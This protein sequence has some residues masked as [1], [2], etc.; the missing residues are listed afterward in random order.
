MPELVALA[1]RRAGIGGGGSSDSAMHSSQPKHQM[2][3]HSRGRANSRAAAL[4]GAGSG[5]R[6]G[7]GAEV[8]AALEAHHL[9]ALAHLAGQGQ[10]L[11]LLVAAVAFG[12]VGDRLDL[13]QLLL[14]AVAEQEAPPAC[15]SRRSRSRR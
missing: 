3:S 10:A 13:R 15:S 1:A 12:L 7:S 14:Q 2:P 6:R 11:D 9:E 4:T 8:D 5:R